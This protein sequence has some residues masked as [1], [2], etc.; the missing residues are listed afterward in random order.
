MASK[1]EVEITADDPK[2]V[3]YALE[4]LDGINSKDIN[5][6]T[7]IKA[8]VRLNIPMMMRNESISV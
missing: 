5:N 3:V 2:A 7:D 8:N 1:I 4:I 6:V